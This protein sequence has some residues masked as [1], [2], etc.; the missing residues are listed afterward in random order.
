MSP[1]SPCDWGG[2]ISKVAGQALLWCTSCN[3]ECLFFLTEGKKISKVT[4][5]AL[6]CKS[7]Y[8]ECFWE[9]EPA[10]APCHPP[11]HAHTKKIKHYME[12]FW[13]FVPLF[14]NVYF[15]VVV[16]WLFFTK[17]LLR[18]CASVSQRRTA[19]T[20]V[21]MSVCTY[22]Y[23]YMILCVRVCVLCVC[24]CLCV[25]VYILCDIDT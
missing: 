8:I 25:C 9:F 6:L 7:C 11:L 12:Y 21:W 19:S 17:K 4:G 20:P 13:E 15:F 16:Q 2:K 1:V 22:V 18:K 5:Q 3:I 23:T 24:V 14:H 10:R